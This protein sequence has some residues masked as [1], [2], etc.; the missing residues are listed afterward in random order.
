MLLPSAVHG[1]DDALAGMIH[2][3]QSIALIPA[4]VRPIGQNSLPDGAEIGLQPAR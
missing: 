2:D 3:A 4:D 1:A